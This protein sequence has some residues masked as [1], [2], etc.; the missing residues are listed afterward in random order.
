MKKLLA[1]TALCL[2]PALAE[3]VAPAALFNPSAPQLKAACDDGYAAV[4]IGVD[5]PLPKYIYTLAGTFGDGYSLQ[6]VQGS[7]L[8]HCHAQASDLA[9]VPDVTKLSRLLVVMLSGSGPSE[10]LE[11]T[12]A[13]AAALSVR[14]KAG[15][16]LVRLSPTQQIEADPRH[17]R[18]NCASRVC[19][20]RGANFYT[21]DLT[22]LPAATRDQAMK[23][24]SV[25]VI[26]NGGNGIETF[27]VDTTQLGR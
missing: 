12:K 26:V 24:T 19:T 22:K 4:E 6:T 25:A 11:D 21:F 14:D 17:W 5:A 3:P 9:A 20:W 13:W 8:S 18:V 10:R 15:K 16:E 1:M 2:S 23:G 27:T 7:I